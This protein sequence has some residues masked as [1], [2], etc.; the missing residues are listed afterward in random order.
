LIN[1]VLDISKLE[2]G[3]I[4]LKYVDI[5]LCEFINEIYNGFKIQMEEKNLDFIIEC[6]NSIGYIY[7]DE[8]RIKQII[9]NLLS[10][11][12]KFTE[13]GQVSIHASLNE[14][15]LTIEVKDTGI[16]ISEDKLE[17]IFDRFKQVDASTTRKYGGTGLGLSIS[18]QLANLLGGDISV[19]SKEGVGS[20]F[21]VTIKANKYK[22]NEELLEK[23]RDMHIRRKEKVIVFNNDPVNFITLVVKLKKDYEVENLNSFNEFLYKVENE[24]Y[25]YIIVDASD[26]K[27]FEL[28]KLKDFKNKTLVV[29]TEEQSNQSQIQEEFN[30][31]YKKPDGLNLISD[32]IEKEK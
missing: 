13:S 12:L 23:D 19:V 9:K 17:F 20:T 27:H 2:A 15:L 31:N 18:K 14:D 4:K 25:K 7:S 6:D 8:D 1:D 26:L 30:F 22:I 11:A 24:K 3:E 21:K 16:G 29:Y 28:L 32:L 10:N 5:K